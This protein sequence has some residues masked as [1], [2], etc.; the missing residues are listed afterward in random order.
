MVRLERGR[1]HERI[2][3]LLGRPHRLGFGRLRSQS[4]RR[5]QA[6]PGGNAPRIR[7]ATGRR[8]RNRGRHHR[9]TTAAHHLRRQNR[10]HG[11]SAVDGN[12]IFE[13]AS[14]TKVFTSL[15]LAD[16]VE[17]GE[18]KLDD[19]ISKFL[20]AAVKLPTRNGKEITLVELATH[21]SGLSR[22]PDNLNPKDWQNPYA[23]YTVDNMY[24][25]LSGYTLPRDIGS[26]YAYSNLGAGLLG[27]VL[28]LKAGSSYESLVID[29]ICKPLGMN[30]TTMILSD[31]MKSRFAVGHNKDGLP[32]EHWDIPTLPR[33][34]GAAFDSQRFAQVRSSK[35]GII[36]V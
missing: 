3:Y 23:D 28:S 19:P 13:I 24:T 7:R 26:K 35:H 25:F 5:Q 30:D 31:E 2:T 29:R 32:A 18:V 6:N 4:S 27:H 12:T 10:A 14:V 15:L 34:R 36:K 1:S 21:T 33:L 20:P 9:R 16:M 11:Q 8:R 17:R 22:I